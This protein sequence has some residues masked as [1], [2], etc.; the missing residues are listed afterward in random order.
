MYA[1][2]MGHEQ[3]I[4]GLGIIF[5]IPVCMVMF[6]ALVAFLNLIHINSSMRRFII[7]ILCAV[8]T[9][10]IGQLYYPDYEHTLMLSLLVY[11]VTS[12]YNA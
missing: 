2:F 4:S 11:I 3:I 6:F 8:T 5:S 12:N 1:F 10:S 7:G 9:Y